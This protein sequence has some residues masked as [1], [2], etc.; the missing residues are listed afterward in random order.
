[1][2]H[3]TVRFRQEQEVRTE[4]IR[5]DGPVADSGRMAAFVRQL[6]DIVKEHLESEADFQSFSC[7]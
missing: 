5:P 4:T 2:G 7:D 3:D 6:Q 1:M